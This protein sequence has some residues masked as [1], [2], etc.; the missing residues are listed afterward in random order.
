LIV[1]LRLDITGWAELSQSQ[2]VYLV[3]VPWCILIEDRWQ[4]GTR[5]E[6]GERG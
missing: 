2:F 3:T 1:A 6:L 4:G 5:Q